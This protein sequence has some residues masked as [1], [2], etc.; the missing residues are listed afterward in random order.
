[1]SFF[2]PV[3]V[4]VCLDPF[5][6]HLKWYLNPDPLDYVKCLL[7]FLCEWK[8]HHNYLSSDIDTI[9]FKQRIASNHIILWVTKLNQHFP[10]PPNTHTHTHKF[11]CIILIRHEWLLPTNVCD[12]HIHEAKMIAQSYIRSH[13]IVFLI[14][15]C[16]IW[17]AC[18]FTD[19]IIGYICPV[20]REIFRVQ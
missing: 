3:M 14:K 5:Y 10:G 11:I 6:I 4:V 18:E 2:V 7:R 19:K 1:M 12:R 20:V 9:Y 15:W 16:R 13:A 17:D 8:N